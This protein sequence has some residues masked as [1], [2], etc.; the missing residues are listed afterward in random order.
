MR[1][2]TVA[3]HSLAAAAAVAAAVAGAAAALPQNLCCWVRQGLGW[4]A[5]QGLQCSRTPC[6]R[7]V[8][9]HSTTAGPE[10]HGSMFCTPVL[11][12]HAL[13]QAWRQVQG[14]PECAHSLSVSD[15]AARSLTPLHKRA[16]KGWLLSHVAGTQEQGCRRAVP[17]GESSTSLSL[18]PPPGKVHYRP[19]CCHSPCMLPRH[20]G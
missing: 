3:V 17:L 12:G 11:R 4:P 14:W 19:S 8:H 2:V 16:H 6:L 9:T 5:A 15:T 18:G 1:G 13:Q 10:I 20:A 7:A